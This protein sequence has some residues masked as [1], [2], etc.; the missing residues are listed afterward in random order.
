MENNPLQLINEK[1]VSLVINITDMSEV[2]KHF[3]DHLSDGYR[4]RRAAIDKN[5]PLVTNLQYAKFLVEALCT[6]KQED[7]AI[8]AWS[9]YK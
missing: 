7:L 5:I 2:T 8:K 9:E 1:K 3:E 6:L 4:I